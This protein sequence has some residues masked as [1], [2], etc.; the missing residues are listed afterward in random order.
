[1]RIGR[2]LYGGCCVLILGLVY[3]LMGT[4]GGPIL[5]WWLTLFLLGLGAYPLCGHLFSTFTDRGWL[6]GK[7]LGFLAGSYVMFLLGSL[8]ILKFGKTG[9]I[10]ST[11]IAVVLIWGICFLCIKKEGM[12]KL[13]SEMPLDDIM[14]R[15][16]LFL[17][18]FAVFAYLKG[19]NPSAYGTERMM[20]YGFM[21]ALDR[22]EYFPVQDFWFA[23]ENLNYYYYGQYLMT[24]LTK[25]SGN[26]VVY[27]YNLALCMCFALCMSLSFSLVYQWM[28]AHT[29]DA[30]K[31]NPNAT[32]E[33]A[34]RG[35]NSNDVIPEAG[36]KHP[37]A[38][39]VFAGTL[40]SLAVTFAANCHYIVFNFLAP[41][42][43]EILQ[44]EGEAPH[45]WFADSTRYIGYHPEVD[46][47]TAHEY[48]AYSFLL[49]DL[50]AHVIN[51]FVV[52]TIL[53]ILFACTRK[54]RAGEK[55]TWDWKKQFS[56]LS[57]LMIGFLIGIC[58]M[59]NYWDFPI[60]FVVAG[61]VLLAWHL[62]SGDSLPVVVARVGVQGI[63]VLTVAVVAAL[64]FSSQ[65]HAMTN[66]F[67]LAENHTRWYQLLILWG[68]PVAVLTGHF[69]SMVVRCKAK[70]F[71]PAMRALEGT[72][73]YVLLL[74]L[75]AAGLILIPEVM[76][77]VDIYSGGF[78]RFNTMFKLSYQAFIL[79]GLLMGFVIAKW[80]ASP[81]SAAQRKWGIIAGVVILWCC[82]Y[83]KTALDDSF[84]DVTDRE[85]HKGLRADAYIYEQRPLDAEAI[86]WINASIPSGSVI[87]EANG[88]SYTLYNCVSVL[89]GLPTVLG[90][91]THEWL[92]HN[93]NEPVDA[94]GDDIREIYTGQDMALKRELLQ[95][96]NVD[97]IYIGTNEYEKYSEDGM[98]V[99]SLLELGETVYF[100]IKADEHGNVIYLLKVN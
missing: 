17:V 82:G 71:R 55:R 98:K 12:R 25:L 38:M 34:G 66:G 5:T 93:S 33:D 88:N 59:E 77:V 44:P 45:Y 64:P 21:A 43:W 53:A 6:F 48:P 79:L 78:K 28:Y 46:D 39:A 36:G 10:V 86:K 96:Y 67:A 30:G 76:Y 83:F 50:H 90:W 26:E 70:G 57:V 56:D 61:A 15:E 1:M 65:F 58:M 13:F 81:Q 75:C 92:W 22:T 7:V 27:G 20:D 73:L 54:A 62:R 2:Y 99:S 60:Y 72:D 14:A 35:S 29:T 23:G 63:M 31:R 9:V 19:F 100:S 24:Y 41:M 68:V 40:A 3:G 8:R 52:L 42:L 95:K 69:V 18:G 51:I 85:R 37:R 89:T 97:Y 16:L 84:G 49:G 32:A 11:L 91:H 4:D 94:R 80:I 47:K 87:L 74:G